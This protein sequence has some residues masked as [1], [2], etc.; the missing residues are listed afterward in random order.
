MPYTV[1]EFGGIA[2]A[3]NTAT[4]KQIDRELQRLDRGLF[5]DP[6]I[7]LHDPRGKYTYWTVKHHIGS[8]VPPLAVLEWRDGNGPWELSMAIIEAVKRRE[9]GL[10]RAVQKALEANKKKREATVKKV[11]DEAYEVA[12]DADKAMGKTGAVLHRGQGLRQAR[13]RA[14]ERGKKV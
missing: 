7:E 5:L 9:G 8:N 12:L 6:E 10:E 1:A 2:A 13:D 4:S 3:Y 14:R 11:G